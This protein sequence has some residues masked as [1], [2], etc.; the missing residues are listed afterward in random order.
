MPNR[1]TILFPKLLRALR[2][3][4][5][6]LLALISTTACR[7]DCIALYSPS[8]TVTVVDSATGKLPTSEVMVRIIKGSSE[9]RPPGVV[10]PDSSLYFLGG[11]DGAGTF[12][13]VVSAPGYAEFRQDSIR[14]RDSRS[15]CGAETQNIRVELR[16]P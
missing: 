1:V 6:V 2:R 11:Q 15:T 10:Q 14:V 16:R 7:S 4:P 9:S 5:L 8:V 12:S 3:G 13:V